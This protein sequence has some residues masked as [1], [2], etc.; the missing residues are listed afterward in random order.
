MSIRII[1]SVYKYK[2]QRALWYLNYGLCEHGIGM[3]VPT[4]TKF[5]VQCSILPMN[6]YK[7]NAGYLKLLN[8]N[9]F[10]QCYMV[11]SVIALVYR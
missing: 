5:F 10:V 6:L 3:K 7:H 2:K 4:S 11:E 8:S 1:V 9:L